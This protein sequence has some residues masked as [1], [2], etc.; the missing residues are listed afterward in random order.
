[1]KKRIL[2]IPLALLLAM[3]LTAIGCPPVEVEPVVQPPPEPIELRLAHFMSTRHLQHTGVMVPFVEEVEKATDGRVKITIFPGGALGRA[4]DQYDAAVTGITDIAFGIHG[5]TPGRFP[6]VSLVEF[7]FL[8][9][10]AEAGSSILWGLYEEFPEIVAEHPDVKVLWLWTCDP[11]QIMT[12]TR[13]IRTLE[14]FEGMRIRAPTAMTVELVRAL[15]ATPVSMPIP[16][17]YDALRMGVLDGTVI[18]LSAAYS[19]RLH[20]V[21]NYVTGGIGLYVSTFFMVMNIDAWDRISLEDQEIIEGIIGKRMSEKAGK[22]YDTGVKLG[23]EALEGA[24]IEIYTL[25]AEELARWQEVLIPVG[26]EWIADIEDQGLPAR[27]IFDA[28]LRILE[29]YKQQVR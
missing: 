2:L 12:T 20:E 23:I 11:G 6:L 27:R 16:E 4:P 7:P 25:P 19:F 29:E 18:P 26:E 5:F 22:V 15:G 9:P 17:L 3:S 28:V 24:G 10:S 14:D 21:V 8:A 1:M 13:P